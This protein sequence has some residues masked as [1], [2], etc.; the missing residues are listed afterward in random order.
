MLSTRLFCERL[1]G[2]GIVTNTLVRSLRSGAI[3]VLRSELPQACSRFYGTPLPDAAGRG[4]GEAS[5]LRSWSGRWLN[6]SWK[7]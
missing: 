6:A 5:R 1:S 3:S 4:F 2:G 7:D